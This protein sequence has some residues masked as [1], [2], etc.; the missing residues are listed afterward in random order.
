MRVTALL[1]TL[2]TTLKRWK[3]VLLPLLGVVVLLGVA[4][5]VSDI[6]PPTAPADPVATY[7]L[8]DDRHRGVLLPRVEGGFVEYGF[9]DWDWYA[10]NCDSWYHAF[11]TVLWPTQGTLGRRLTPARNGRELRRQ[12]YWMRLYEIIVARTN[13]EALRDELQHVYAQGADREVYN[14]RYR[15]SFV[16]SGDGY[17]LF[18]NCNDAVASW[19]EKLGCSVSWVPVR[20]DLNVIGEE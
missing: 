9:G 17:W 8:M 6:R 19:L 16:P 2:L 4:G 11:D 5:C 12:F 1:T 3:W 13:M 10:E 7:L 14:P 20:L 18:Y 15:M